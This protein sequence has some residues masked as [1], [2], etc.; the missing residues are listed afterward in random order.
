MC[1]LPTFREGVTC[2]LGNCARIRFWHDKWMGNSDLASQFPRLLTL[3]TRKDGTMREMWQSDSEGDRWPFHLRRNFREL[4]MPML[5]NLANSSSLP[6]LPLG[7]GAMVFNDVVP[8]LRKMKL[9][10]KSLTWY[11]CGY[12]LGR[13]MIKFRN[14]VVN[15]EGVLEGTVMGDMIDCVVVLISSSTSFLPK[16]PKNDNGDKSEDEVLT[17]SILTMGEPGLEEGERGSEPR[18]NHVGDS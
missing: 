5:E 13:N 8:Q 12:W 7:V 17:G 11:W 16:M 1:M 4:E 3:T 6:A 10:I 15:W 2:K 9:E 18:P 14:L